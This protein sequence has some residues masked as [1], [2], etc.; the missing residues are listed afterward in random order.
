MHIDRPKKE[1]DRPRAVHRRVARYDSGK[2]VFDL[3]CAESWLPSPGLPVKSWGAARSLSQETGEAGTASAGKHWERAAARRHV[4]PSVYQH[5]RRRS[6]SG[7]A[8]RANQ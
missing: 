7:L 2:F 5:G 4:R 6:G 1:M 3:L 8:P